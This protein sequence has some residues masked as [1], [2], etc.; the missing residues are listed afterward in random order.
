MG[1][2]GERFVLLDPPSTL[3]DR[4]RS[5]EFYREKD[6]FYMVSG[7][8]SKPRVYVYATASAVPVPSSKAETRD[9]HLEPTG[10][11]EPPPPE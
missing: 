3:N 11:H 4:Y 7:G 8:G 2:K 9:G 6:T 1:N 10:A 5:A